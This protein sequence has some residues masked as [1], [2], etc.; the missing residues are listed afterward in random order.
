MS[1]ARVLPGTL[2]G[3]LVAPPSKSYTHRALV[4]GHLA[5]RPYDVRRPLDADD[6]RITA[7]AVGVLGSHVRFGARRWKVSPA[8]G[9]IRR[10]ASI[11]CGESGTTLRFLAALA[12]RSDRTIELRGHGRLPDRPIAELF[13]ALEGL[14]A[15]CTHPRGPLSLPASV[16]G[17]VH[18]GRVRI[19]SSKSSQFASALLLVLPTVTGDSMLELSGPIVSE[20]YIEATLA[21]LRHHRVRVAR[22][23]RRF[24][25]PGEQTYRGAG[26]T[27]PG[28]ASSAAYFWAA[29]AIT[30]G[31][32]RVTGIPSRWP[33]AD[34]AVLELLSSAGAS[35][36]RSAD[37]ATVSGGDLRSFS[38]NLTSAPDLYPLAGVIA[39][40]IPGTSRLGGAAHV[41][42]KES[43]RKAGTR[44]LVRAMGA[45]VR[46][47]RG[48]LVIR[49]R[50]RPRAIHYS[51]SADHRLVMSA[52]VG[53][54]RGSV[55][56][57]I[58]NAGAVAKSYPDFWK[59]LDS[60][61]R[62][63]GT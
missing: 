56:S 44:E 34:L 41:A 52:A 8:P 58:G 24:S 10:R 36:R 14:G 47:E 33:Q 2:S 18:G 43:D 27:V 12:A 25:I 30:G 48:D 22:R 42:H 4:A 20:P 31:P 26:M 60:L 61:R 19:D 54:L 37:G 1:V 9:T 23:G 16:R 55:P 29:G 5:H 35:V 7:R 39:A 46:S 57:R 28:D 11:D 50:A 15:T 59:A 53:A 62:P 40:S 38:V 49:G 13:D 3:T 51:G 21:V 17:P 32:V 6:T 63:T 45:E